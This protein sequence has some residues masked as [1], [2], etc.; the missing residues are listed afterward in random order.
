[1]ILLLFAAALQS[2]RVETDAGCIKCHEAQVEDWRE[3]IHARKGVGCVKC[4]G[5]ETVDPAKSKPHL[6]TT[7]FK[8]G[9]KKAN[10]ALC[11]GCHKEEFAA[12][13]ASAHAEDTRDDSGKVKG[14][15]SCHAFHETSV[16][17][18]RAI[19]KENC[20]TCHRAGSQKYRTGEE[21]IAFAEALQGDTLKALRV[22]QHSTRYAEIEK[23]AVAYNSLDRGPRRPPWLWAVPAIPAL[24]AVVLWIRSGRRREAS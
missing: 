2:Q 20:A 9:T 21:Y 15:S 16:A 12:F 13:D 6:F 19:L 23:R 22:S 3:S 8:R 10:P 4:H 1:V 18:R 11:A 17:D 5:A 7:G 14:C 24:V